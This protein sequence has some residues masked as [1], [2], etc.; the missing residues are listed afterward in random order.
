MK[1]PRCNNEDK[2]LFYKGS[3]GY[4]C[5]GCIQF[6]RQLLLDD[7]ETE[8][9][10]EINDEAS[11][12][13][14]PFELTKY[15]QKISE[16]CAKNIETSDVLLHCV[17]GS[18]KTELTLKSIKNALD[19]K[20][21][22]GF[23]ISR[24]QVVIEIWARL[25]NLFNKAKVIK[26]CQGYTK[27]L[28]GDIIVL[29]THQLYR[30]YHTFDLLILDECDGF[31]YKGN[32]TLQGIA[33]NSCI[34][35]IIYTTAT[36]DDYLKKRVKDKTIYYLTLNVRPHGYKMPIPKV[37]IAPKA[38]LIYRLIKFINH[39]KYPLIIFVPTIKMANYYYL[40]FKKFYKCNVVSS[41]T[42]K[43]DQI[44]NEF[45]NNKYDFVIATTILER[46]ITIPLV[47][48][49]VL[50][51]NH[52]VFDQSSLIQIIGRMGRSVSRPTGN[53]YILCNEYSK[54]VKDCIKELNRLNEMP[55]MQ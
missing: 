35:H 47:D 19:R 37:I 40:L 10:N 52:K 16:E 42:D 18:G 32:K 28:D 24:R 33:H 46:G 49:I 48:I 5:R 50:Y 15:Q 8:K 38:Y 25:T 44:V 54:D 53:G 1:C 39:T 20:Q 2:T 14:M 27:E 12:L 51:G 30:Y 45:K 31:P 9:L 4:Y 23:A 34:G 21:K 55:V 43:L 36:L 17:C 26:V 11:E 22:V 13:T 29:T 41:K 3:K 6:K 7:I